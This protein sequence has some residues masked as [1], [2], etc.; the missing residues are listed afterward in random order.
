MN[1]IIVG[2]GKVGKT[3]TAQLTAEGHDVVVVDVHPGVVDYVVNV[4]DVRGVCGNGACYDVLVEASVRET[5]V[6]IATTSTDEINILSC[7][8]AKKLGARHT[9]A[10]IRNPEYERQRSPAARPVWAAP[11]SG[12]SSSERLRQTTHRRHL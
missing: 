4:C 5:D 10:R 11:H 12:R 2:L 9:I 1:I 3:L 6:L 7:M 8:L